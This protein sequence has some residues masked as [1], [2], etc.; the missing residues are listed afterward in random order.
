MININNLDGQEERMRFQNVIRMQLVIA[1]L[2]T[3]L[4]FPALTKAQ[5]ISNTAFDDGPNAAPFARP[6]A[7]QGAGNS[8]SA[9]PSAQTTPAM[10]AIHAPVTGQ[11]TTDEQEPSASLIWIGA[12]LVWI[13]AIG[14]YARGPAKRLTRELRSLRNPTVIPENSVRLRNQQDTEGLRNFVLMKGDVEGQLLCHLPSRIPH[15][16]SDRLCVNTHADV[17]RTVHR[18]RPLHR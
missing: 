5:E 14:L 18:D 15:R 12:A 11:Q 2:G 17:F 8:V 16:R 9:L 3:A 1:G 10:T 6:V 4:L 7:A 13:G